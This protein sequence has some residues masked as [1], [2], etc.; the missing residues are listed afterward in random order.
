[1]MNSRYQVT[2][3]LAHALGMRLVYDLDLTHSQ[4]VFTVESLYCGHHR[5]YRF[6]SRIQKCLYLRSF[7]YTYSRYRS[8][9]PCCWTLW[10]CAV[11]FRALPCCMLVRKATQYY[12]YKCLFNLVVM[13][14][15]FMRGM[16]DVHIY[17]WVLNSQATKNTCPICRIVGC[18]HFRDY[19]GE[20][21]RAP[22]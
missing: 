20:P 13:H 1:M 6:V 14:A 5:D 16:Q 8:V 21:E 7:Q 2:F 18:P 17:K 11:C 15:S 10:N 19:W 22:H 3:L 9:Y 4:L 12:A